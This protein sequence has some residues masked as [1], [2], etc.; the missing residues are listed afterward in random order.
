MT[1]FV[2]YNTHSIFPYF[3]SFILYCQILESEV[4]KIRVEFP[5]LSNATIGFLIFLNSFEKK[6]KND[7][8]NFLIGSERVKA[9]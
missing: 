2:Y 8:T 6:V 5:Q 7:K 1:A 3:L 4:H 9:K